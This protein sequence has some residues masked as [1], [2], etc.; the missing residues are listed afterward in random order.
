MAGQ[1]RISPRQFV[2]LAFLS[3]LTPMIRRFPRVL[4]ET[5]GRTAWL[6]AAL[7]VLPA[8]AAIGFAALLCRGRTA[9][10]SFSALLCDSLGRAPGRALT[11]LYGLWMLFYAAFLLRAGAL[12]FIST[13]YPDAAPWVFLAV[14]AL[15]CGIAALGRLKTL[16]RTAMVV[17]AGPVLVFAAAFALTAKDLDLPLLLPVTTADLLPDLAGAAQAVNALS[18]V[19]VLGF[20]GDRLERR[21]R[22]RDFAGWAAALLA[23]L[24]CMTAS[25]I[26]MFG[27]ALTAQLSYPF[28]MLVRDVTVLGSLERTEPV[29]IALWVFSD[30]LFISLL[31]L[32]AG[33]ALREALGFPADDGAMRRTDLSRGRWLL[34]L[35]TALAL[36]ASLL[37]VSG[38]DFDLLSETVV[39]MLNAALVFAL[40]LLAL[41]IGALRRKRGRP[42]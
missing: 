37:P 40:P 33:K 20:C 17:R 4:S 13:V 6:A 2:A 32:L 21:L 29:V 35:G 16:A 18:A 11:A 31:L 27:P 28:F 12:R 10:V 5:A 24:A 39:P 42:R 9:P 22:L 23:M 38:R 41:L 30:Y 15:L 19:A 26:G 1:D 36:A 7:S 8:A 3:A 34:P 25:C 14:G